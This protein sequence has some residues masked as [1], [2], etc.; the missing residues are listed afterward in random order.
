[1]ARYREHFYFVLVI[2][3]W[4]WF[5][6]IIGCMRTSEYGITGLAT[7]PNPQTE[8]ATP[9][10]ALAI[11]DNVAIRQLGILEPRPGFDNVTALT[12]LTKIDKIIPYDGDVLYI[13]SAV[14]T[15]RWS[16]NSGVSLSFTKHQIRGVEARKNLYLTTVTGVSGTQTKLVNARDTTAKRVGLRAPGVFV[17]SAASTGPIK[18]GMTVSYRAIGKRTDANNLV[19]KSQPS[20]RAVYNPASEK[21]PTLRVYF[22]PTAGYAAGDEMRLYRTLNSSL[23]AGTGPSDEHFLV[24][25]ATLTST[26]I[27]NSYVDIVDSIEDANLGEALY[28]NGTQEGISRRN[29]APPLST[30]LELFQGSVFASNITWPH[31]YDLLFTNGSGL[32]GVAAGIGTRLDVNATYTNGS[33]VIAVTDATGL[34]VGMLVQP[35]VIASW[36][37][38][39]PITIVSISGTNVTVSETYTGATGGGKSTFF[40]DSVGIDTSSAG[41]SIKYYP[42]DPGMLQLSMSIGYSALRIAAT[43]VAS[44]LC[45]GDASYTTTAGAS[46]VAGQLHE[47]LLERF[48]PSAGAFYLW[49]THGSEYQ[50]ALPEPAASMP[51]GQISTQDSFPSGLTWTKQDE[52]E[53]YM[54]GKLWLVGN[55]KAPIIRIVALTDAL[56]I[57]KGRGDGI[58]RLTGDGERS[59]W[60]V[61]RLD[62][63]TGLLHPELVTRLEGEIYGWSQTG[64][65][66]I[67]AIGQEMLSAPILDQTR[68][69]ENTLDAS[70][71]AHGYAYAA[72]NLPK[73]ELIF[74]LPADDTNNTVPAKAYIYNTLTKTWYTWFGDASLAPYTMVFDPLGRRLRAG[75]GS[76]TPLA[77]NLSTADVQTADTSISIVVT[78]CDAA[79]NATISGGSGWTPVVGDLVQHT[80][81][82]PTYGI[83]TA[84]TDAT[85]FQLS[86]PIATGAG[87]AW[88]GFTSTVQWL[89]KNPSKTGQT[90]RWLDLDA[91]W[92]DTFGLYSWTWTISGP[93]NGGNTYSP[94]YTRTYS[95]SNARAE[96][97][98]QPSRNVAEDVQFYFKLAI[99]NADARWRL[100]GFD[101]DFG[102]GARQAVR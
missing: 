52:P 59:G 50:P 11:A 95:R 46:S 49:A 44:A 18:A 36:S 15:A 83:V 81:I 53:H 82:P 57:F 14:S 42:A 91:H 92:E 22:S 30:D 6:G 2:L 96:T 71:S 47:V 87:Y 93:S 40:Y 5:C 43:S 69:I 8:G 35:I 75:R 24:A 16:D 98:V 13:D 54:R 29:V 79:G 58:Y 26:N 76:A 72:A 17:Q 63:T 85:H 45:E 28:T 10:G 31:A 12:G 19:A 7:A 77:E 90:K 102:A 32:S 64:M 25:A 84:V 101:A 4:L 20:G 27:S 89:P 78:A 100:G 97:I 68:D 99:R 86:G 56:Y 33:A 80:A 38:T 62:D 21:T 37:G 39:D 61:K 1:M 23:P 74:G 34:K 3:F 48:S 41:G 65:V 94:S 70:A 55:P 60:A 88:I 66:K 51:T 73:H 67:T 9:P